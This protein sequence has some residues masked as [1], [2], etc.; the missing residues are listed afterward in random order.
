MKKRK[1]E[2]AYIYNGFGFPVVLHN[3]PMINVR[4]VWTPDISG[5]DWKKLYFFFWHIIP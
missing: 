1:I 2:K 3:V 4:G 5:T